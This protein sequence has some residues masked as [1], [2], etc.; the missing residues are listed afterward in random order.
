MRTFYVNIRKSDFFAKNRKQFEN[1]K[2]HFKVNLVTFLVLLHQFKLNLTIKQVEPNTYILR[3]GLR[4]EKI[5]LNLQ[6]R[7]NTYKKFYLFK[8]C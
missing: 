3:T 1:V 6:S 4:F 7:H 8:N 2:K 5:G